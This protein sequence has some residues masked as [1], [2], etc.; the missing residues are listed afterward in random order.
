MNSV[1][2]LVSDP[3]HVISCP[4]QYTLN[5]I[6]SVNMFRPQRKKNKGQNVFKVMENW[7]LWQIILV[8][9]ESALLI[10]WRNLFAFK[11]YHNKNS[12]RSSRPRIKMNV[13]ELIKVPKN[14]FTWLIFQTD[15]DK[16]HFPSFPQESTYQAGETAILNCSFYLHSD[17]L[18]SVKWYKVQFMFNVL[19]IIKI[20]F[21]FFWKCYLPHSKYAYKTKN[22][23]R[24][25]FFSYIPSQSPSSRFF[26]VKGMKLDVSLIF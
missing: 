1:G 13:P 24:H 10:T 16:S 17:Q 26:P 5:N 18:Y 20:L 21:N 19:W 6:S 22:Q 2:P 4:C 7:P 9:A 25:Q 23:G 15:C 8:H 3:W 12:G 14:S 11:D